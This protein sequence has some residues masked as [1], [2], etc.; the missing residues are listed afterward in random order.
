MLSLVYQTTTVRRRERLPSRAMSS[1]PSARPPGRPP[2][3]SREE[4]MAAAMH[5][6]LRGQRVDVRAIAGE[7]GLGRAT[8]YRWFGSREQLIGEVLFAAAKPLLD[9]ARVSAR[10]RGGAGVLG[11]FRRLHPRPPPPPPPPHF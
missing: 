5:R 2:A 8:I 10:R 4:V 3:A 11:T 6:Y 1:A 9:D 7:L